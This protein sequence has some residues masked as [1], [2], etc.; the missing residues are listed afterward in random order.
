[1]GTQTRPQLNK[2]TPAQAQRGAPP[3]RNRAV[4]SP[5]W[6]PGPMPEARHGTGGGSRH[7][8]NNPAS[9]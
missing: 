9:H 7:H 5:H 8:Q 1:M 4:S 2:Q 6:S 3:W